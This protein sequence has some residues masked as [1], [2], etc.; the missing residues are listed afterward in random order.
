MGSSCLM[1][2]RC[3]IPSSIAVIFRVYCADHTYCT[4]RFAINATTEMIKASAADKLQLNRP[5]EDLVLA[6]VKS[7]GERTVFKD[8]D[9]SIPTALYLN[10]RIFVSSKDHIDALVS[11]TSSIR[12]LI[13]LVH[14]FGFGFW[15]CFCHPLFFVHIPNQNRINGF[16]YE[17]KCRH[18]CRSRRKSLKAYHSIW[19]ILAQ[20]SLH[21][22]LR[23]SI[24]IYFGRCTNTNC[25]II[26]LVDIILARY[27]SFIHTYTKFQYG[28]FHCFVMR[29]SLSLLSLLLLIV[30]IVGSITLISSIKIKWFSME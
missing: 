16:V 23:N 11:T 19:S 3:S 29:L 7:H 10:A 6:E 28:D 5:N 4:L 30:L 8:H 26:H 14:F 9:V 21:S 20:K 18:R 2:W 24:G 27:K 22:I 1:R 17:S 15:F 13:L 25:S 12:N